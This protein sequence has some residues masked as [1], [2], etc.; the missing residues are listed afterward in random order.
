MGK[1]RIA[2][3]KNVIWDYVDSFF[4]CFSQWLFPSECYPSFQCI[5]FS[6]RFSSF[7]LIFSHSTFL[8][9]F[10]FTD[11][12]SL[13][14]VFRVSPLYFY[15]LFLF[16]T[17]SFSLSLSVSFKHSFTKF[18]LHWGF[19]S[20]VLMYYFWLISSLKLLLS[21]YFHFSHSHAGENKF[22]FS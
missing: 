11:L 5:Y 21:F 1:L 8:R 17:R 16:C 14:N 10:F 7:S 15:H 3:G 20:L 22:T 18:F 4:Q 13:H 19:S 9:F 6:P 12:F 2:K